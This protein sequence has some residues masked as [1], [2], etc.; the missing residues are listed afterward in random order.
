YSGI[1]GLNVA[2]DGSLEVATAFGTLRETKPRLYQQMAS[3]KVT[4]NGRYQLVS[5]RSYTFE[6][7][8]HN[9]LY[10]LV[11]DPTLLYSTYLGGSAGNQVDNY[12]N[13]Y[14]T[15]VAVDASG[16]AYV[17]GY[18]ASTD[19]PTTVGAFQV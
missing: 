12:T 9:P 7:E 1:D 10:A 14:A 19:F 6:V 17:A 15:G 13:E 4:V 5:E 11:V 2:K 8:V 3:K 18:T 16:S